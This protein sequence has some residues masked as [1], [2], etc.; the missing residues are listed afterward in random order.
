MTASLHLSKRYCIWVTALLQ[1]MNC[2]A[3]RRLHNVRSI[4]RANIQVMYRAQGR[5]IDRWQLAD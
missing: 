1:F 4:K 3:F 2:M 5:R